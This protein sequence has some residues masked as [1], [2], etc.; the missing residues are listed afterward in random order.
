MWSLIAVH[1]VHVLHSPILAVHN[2]TVYIAHV[3]YEQL[4]DCVAQVHYELHAKG[5]CSPCT[6]LTAKGP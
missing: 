2:G 5:L 4:R 6:L 3:H 1:N